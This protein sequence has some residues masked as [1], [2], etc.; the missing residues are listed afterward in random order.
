MTNEVGEIL[1]DSQE[2]L[3]RTKTRGSGMEFYLDPGL[4]N[5]GWMYYDSTEH[6]IV[7]WKVQNLAKISWGIRESDGINALK[8]SVDEVCDLIAGFLDE[9]KPMLDLASHIYVEGQAEKIYGKQKG[10]YQFANKMTAW[11]Y[12]VYSRYPKKTTFIWPKTIKS[13]LEIGKGN[14]HANKQASIDYTSDLLTVGTRWY[15]EFEEKT[16]TEKHNMADVFCM[17]KVAQDTK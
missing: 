14:W 13:L 17:M 1:T 12:M 4:T 11:M 5:V 10:G 15:N 2:F 8:L 7:E 6:R 9:V 3:L 16:W